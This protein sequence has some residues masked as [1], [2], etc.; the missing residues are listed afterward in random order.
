MPL[1]DLP[2]ERCNLKTGQLRQSITPMTEQ[3]QI[4]SEHARAICEEIGARLRCALKGDYTILPRKLR[5]LVK[6]L[7]ALEQHSPPLVPSMKDFTGAQME[8]A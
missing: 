5:E 7:D 6:Q 8:T 3:H 1:E 2:L 4:A